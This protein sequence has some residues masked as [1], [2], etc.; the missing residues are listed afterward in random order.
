M[1][2]KEVGDLAEDL[3]VKFLENQGYKIIERNF[4]FKNF[5]EIDIIALKKNLINFVEVKSL[6][7]ESEFIPEFHFSS[8]KYK[9]IEKIASFYANKFNYSN[10]IISLITVVLENSKINYYENIKI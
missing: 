2:K 8:K 6:T 1:N 7:E 9:K 5:G 3:A 10:W 4:R